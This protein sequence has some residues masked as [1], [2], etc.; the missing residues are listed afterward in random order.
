MPKSLMTPQEHFAKI[1]QPRIQ[2][3]VFDRSHGYKT[4]FDAGKLIPFYL[5]EALPGDTF[6]MKNVNVF[7]RINTLI[8]PV[9]DNIMIDVHFFSVPERLIWENFKK[10]N[11]EQENP[12]DSISYTFPEMTSPVGGYTENSIYDYFGLPTKVAGYEHRS[13]PLR[14]YN[15]IFNEWYRDENLQD[16]VTVRKTD[17]GDLDSDFTLLDRGKRKD[18]F[19]SA[20]PWAQKG[21]AVSVPLG[22]KAYVKGIGPGTNTYTVADANA[23]EPG[24]AGT[25]TF[26]PYKRIDNND[27]YTQ[28]DSTYTGNPDIYA[29]LS[30]ATAA[31]VNAWRE[32]F[33][34]QELLELDARGGTRYTEIIKSHFNVDSPDKRLQRPELLGGFTTYLNINP[35][36]QTGE[37]GTTKQGNLS[38]IGT[39][40]DSKRGFIKSFTEHEIVIGIISAR[41]DLNYQQG[42]NKLWKRSTRYDLYWPSFAHLGEQ[43]ITNDEIFTQG[44][45]ADDAV[46]GYQERYADYKF[47]P[48]LVTSQLRSNA[49]AS[50]DSWHLAQD[51]ASLPALDD[52][53]IKEQPP[54]D[55]IVAVT[56]EPDFELDVHMNLKC[57]RPMPTYAIPASLTKL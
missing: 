17:S 25:T 2:R 13:G 16:S 56:S 29:D 6:N 30:S 8:K 14:A 5:D 10:M 3:S 43:A 19:T 45:A 32:A 4:T 26:N 35:I 49:S 52:T 9:M 7:G 51:F 28:E 55:R 40:A 57:A 22:D 20:L 15:L 50:L 12:G 36:A 23:Y 47:K 44:T 42:L 27:W 18:Y 41:A 33:Q 38:G 24:S 48:S 11:G 53:F 54:M 37:S 46:F 21:D 34:T 39:F 1:A 31:T